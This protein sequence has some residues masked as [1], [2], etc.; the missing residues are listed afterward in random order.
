[1][2]HCYSLFSLASNFAGDLYFNHPQAAI[3]IL[4]GARGVGKTTCCQSLVRQLKQ[5]GVSLGGVLSCARFEG[6]EK[7]G[8]VLENL[9]TGEQHLMGQR[10]P[11]ENYSF[12]VGNW[13]FS[14]EVLAW[15]NRCLEQ[16]ASCDVVIFDECGILE[17]EQGGG[18]Q[19][20]L[21]LMDARDYYLGVVVVRPLLLPI[22]QARW[23]EAVVIDLD[24]RQL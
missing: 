3:R 20:G 2:D 22:A 18:F 12:R 6:Q 16:A 21:T 24:E 15:G 17:L 19:S 11:D 5:P 10:E 13:Y 1:M 4:T 7:T 14:P 9:Q 8:I 23:P